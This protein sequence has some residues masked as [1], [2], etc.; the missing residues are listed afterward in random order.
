MALYHGKAA[1]LQ[2][3]TQGYFAA[4][5]PTLDSFLKPFIAPNTPYSIPLRAHHRVLANG[6]FPEPSNT[7]RV[8]WEG[9]QAI[10]GVILEARELL[11]D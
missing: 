5:S 6:T 9:L 3:F 1:S 8:S 4:H 10:E 2:T 7:D 11:I